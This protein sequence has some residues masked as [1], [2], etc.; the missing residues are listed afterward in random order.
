MD[1]QGAE[2]DKFPL[3][4][5][6]LIG[7]DVGRHLVIVAFQDDPALY[8]GCHQHLHGGNIKECGFTKRQRHFH[9][10]SMCGR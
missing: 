9:P 2:S 4:K 5:S 7:T 1:M 3:L 8:L 10:L 6:K